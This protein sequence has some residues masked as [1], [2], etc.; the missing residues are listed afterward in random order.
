MLYDMMHGGVVK[1]MF[2]TIVHDLV[3]FYYHTPAH[4]HTQG[5][6]SP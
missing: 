6:L 5:R 1:R 2:E 4:T 3:A